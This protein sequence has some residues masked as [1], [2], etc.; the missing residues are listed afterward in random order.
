MRAGCVLLAALAI[1]TGLTEPPGGCPAQP[2][3]LAAMRDCL[4]PVLVFAPSAAD[5]RFVE[6][7]RKLAG[8]AAGMRE[9]EMALVPL[10]LSGL[11]ASS[12]S[13]AILGLPPAEAAVARKRFGVGPHEF[14]VLLLGKDGGE[15]LTSAAPLTAEKLFGE[16]DRMPMRRQEMRGR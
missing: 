7:E 8:S 1:H 13:T 14:R 15:K 3:S 6:Q 2:Q 12:G 16:V 10:L 11:A 9:R 5:A 4:R